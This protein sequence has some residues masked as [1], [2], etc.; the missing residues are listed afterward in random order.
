MSN[1]EFES[2]MTTYMQKIKERFR[3]SS[4]EEPADVPDVFLKEFKVFS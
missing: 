3:E 4:F 2:K 1:P